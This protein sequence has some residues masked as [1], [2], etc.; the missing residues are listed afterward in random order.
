MR[1]I[2]QLIAITVVLLLSSCKTQNLMSG[3]ETLNSQQLIDSVFSYQPGYQYRI[4]SDDKISISVWGQDEL[5]VGSVYGIYNSNEV[6]GKWVMVDANGNIEVPKLGTLNVAGKTIPQLK[7]TLRLKL[8]KW[9]IDPI[10][11]VRVLNKEISILGEL[12]T[13]GNYIVDKDHNHLLEMIG[14]AGGYDFYAN[15]KQIKVIRQEGLNVRI[16]TFDLTKSDDYLNRNILLHPGDIVIVPSKNFKAF[17]K[18]V[19]TIIPFT[20]AISAAAILLKLF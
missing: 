2:I 16:C 12:K 15:L 5:S 19:S 4:K 14:K 3:S 1:P 17:D 7:D 13:P 6:Y 9:I 10:L 11:D 18:R 8:K 20:T